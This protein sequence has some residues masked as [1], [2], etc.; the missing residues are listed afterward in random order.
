MARV[1]AGAEVVQIFDTWAGSLPE[2]QFRAWSI[3]PTRKIVHALRA[4]FPGL[5]VIGFPRGSGALAVDYARATEI[6]GIGLD[7]GMSP[8]WARDHLQPLACLQGNLDPLLLVAGG[9]TMRT[10]AA[11]ILKTLGRGPFIFNLGHGIVPQT[12]PDHVAEL[13][14][15]V[16][17]TK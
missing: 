2:A 5:P 4:K 17:A 1:E 10:A 7:T 12:P 13:V 11:H 15:F 6:S 3:A 9:E 16:R 8:A 14:E